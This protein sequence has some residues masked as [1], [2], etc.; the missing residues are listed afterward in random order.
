M[1]VTTSELATVATAALNA[2]EMGVA[3]GHKSRNWQIGEA[4][5]IIFLDIY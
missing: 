4:P 5:I 1:I 2:P 3:M